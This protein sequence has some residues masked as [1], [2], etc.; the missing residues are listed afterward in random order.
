[1]A[2]VSRSDWLTWTTVVPVVSLIAL[3]L[4]WGRPLPPALVGVVTLLLGVLPRLID[5][6]LGFSAH[7]GQFGV[8]LFLGFLILGFQGASFCDHLFQQLFVLSLLGLG[9]GP[10]RFDHRLRLGPRLG[11]H[12][13]NLVD[14][15][16]QH[17]RHPV[18][19]RVGRG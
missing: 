2:S 3:G 13:G 4:A 11:L 8:E 16:T 12:L 10:G 9:F 6:R 1:M 17:R 15:T 18:L 19:Q 7:P 5:L 14:R